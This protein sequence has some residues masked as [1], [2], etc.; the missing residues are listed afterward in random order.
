[1]ST[2]NVLPGG[3]DAATWQHMNTFTLGLGARG[4]MVYSTTYKSD[5]SGDYYSVK[6]GATPSSTVCTWQASGTCTWPTP[7]A[8]LPENIDDLWHAAVNGRGQYFAATDPNSLAVGLNAALQA[9]TEMTSDSA[10]AT[11]SNPNV[12]SGDNYI[13]SSTF[14]SGEWYGELE[15]R[16]IES[17]RGRWQ[18][19]RADRRSTID[20]KASRT[21]PTFDSSATHKL[22]S[23]L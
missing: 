17:Q 12:T 5:T 7:G 19:L 21:I 22:K 4:R 6:T 10:A 9:V 20:A 3:D 14:R 16:T 13:F 8:D 15:R 23:F 1:M 18:R 11:T 2:D